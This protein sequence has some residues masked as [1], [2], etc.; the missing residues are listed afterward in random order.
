VSIINAEIREVLPRAKGFGE[1]HRRVVVGVQASGYRNAEESV[2]TPLDTHALGRGGDDSVCAR[3]RQNGHSA[4][5]RRALSRSRLV[6][7]EK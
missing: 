6:E 3:R 2:F 5:V 1:L 4:L 7:V